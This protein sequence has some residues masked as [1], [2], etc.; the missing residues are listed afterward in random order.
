MKTITIANQKGGV[1]KST[2]A[3]HLAHFAHEQGLKVVLVDLDAQGNSSSALIKAFAQNKTL[4][5]QLF[6]SGFTL[7]PVASG[8]HVFAGD[9]SL[10]DIKSNTGVF[11]E[12]FAKLADYGFDLCIIDTS[13]TAS[14]IQIIPVFESDYVISPIELQS[15][16]YEG[17]MPFLNVVANVRKQNKASRGLDRPKFLGL[18]PSRVWNQSKPQKEDLEKLIN[19]PNFVQNLVLKGKAIIP[20]RQAYVL[21]G[22]TGLPI[23]SFRKNSSARSEGVNMKNIC[24]SIIGE[25]NINLNSEKKK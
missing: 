17:A 4:A 3:L 19:N 7:N 12:N 13:P 11:A 1:G 5:F 15:W 20:N 8:V 2:L 18:L 25:M 14:D 16:S 10:S 22:N 9:E 21:A 23:W 6:E 24:R